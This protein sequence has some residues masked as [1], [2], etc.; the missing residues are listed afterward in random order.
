MVVAGARS[1]KNNRIRI[2]KKDN[3]FS[4][5][6]NGK[7]SVWI[8][9]PDCENGQSDAL[10]RY[11]VVYLLDAQEHFGS[12][13]TMI[14]Q[15]DEANGKRMFPDMIVVGI[16]NTNRSRDLT[17][18]HSMYDSDEKKDRSFKSS[19]GG[20]KFIEFIEKELIP[21]VDST[22][23]VT[24]QRV[25]VGHSLGGLTA[26]N[27]LINHTV[28]FNGYIASDPS[29]WWDNKMMLGQAREALKVKRFNGKS[30][31]ISMANT[32]PRGMDIA[33]ARNDTSPQSNHI[34]CVLELTDMLENNRDNGLLFDYKYYDQ[35][36]H[37]TVP[38]ITNYDG[39]RFLLGMG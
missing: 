22:Y 20:E 28:L 2:C 27:I 9:L 19:G 37:N 3:L 39:L 16:P 38:Q 1:V 31:Y 12:F 17:P 10:Q 4:E 25:L 35:H 14:Q 26:I 7:R 5:I 13:T 34:R 23:P 24:A 29:L 32:M 8:Y 18:T 36:D 6:L 11:P 30:L 21:Y 15:V 33:Q